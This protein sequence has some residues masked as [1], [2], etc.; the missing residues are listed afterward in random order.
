MEL[1]KFVPSVCALGTAVPPWE[2]SG[3]TIVDVVLQVEPW[4]DGAREVCEGLTVDALSYARSRSPRTLGV[5]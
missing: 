2:H 4:K 1:L 5:R 3:P